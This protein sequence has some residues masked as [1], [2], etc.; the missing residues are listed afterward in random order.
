MS[1]VIDEVSV[2]SSE[3]IGVCPHVQVAVLH[4]VPVLLHA[5]PHAEAASHA[6]KKTEVSSLIVAPIGG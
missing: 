2:A 6:T 4:S 5:A 3:E 1:I